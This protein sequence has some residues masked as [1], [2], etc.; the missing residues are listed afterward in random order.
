MEKSQTPPVLGP[1]FTIEEYE[2][3]RK[4]IELVRIRLLKCNVSNQAWTVDPQNHTLLI[5]LEESFNKFDWGFESLQDCT[6][7]VREDETEVEQGVIQVT[8]SACYAFKSDF[9][10]Q[11]DDHLEFI[12]AFNTLHL[13]L[14]LYPYIRLFVQDISSKMDW[15]PIVLPL[16][17]PFDP[18]DYDETESVNEKTEEKAPAKEPKKRTPTKKTK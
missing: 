1:S 17:Q 9:V 11:L 18:T 10:K 13:R 15:A 4:G 8:Y 6:V 14:H 7:K 16:D 3:F 12:E 5:G 2:Q